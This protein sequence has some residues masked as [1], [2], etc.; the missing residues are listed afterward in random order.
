MHPCLRQ[1]QRRRQLQRRL[2]V[3]TLQRREVFSGIALQAPPSDSPAAEVGSG[4]NTPLTQIPAK[5]ADQ[6]FGYLG[7]QVK[8]VAKTTIAG[9]PTDPLPAAQKVVTEVAGS[10]TQLAAEKAESVSEA[11]KTATIAVDA[12]AKISSVD[13][14]KTISEKVIS[15][16]QKAADKV[17]KPAVDY[18]VKLAKKG[19]RG[20]TSVVRSLPFI[21]DSVEPKKIFA[22]AGANVQRVIGD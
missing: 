18:A 4:T 20:L 5:V 16:I 8:D 12:A 15:K 17:I 9:L 11:A 13:V 3:E 14:G 1:P 7:D 10:L 21:G 2:T 19:L 6:V 22:E